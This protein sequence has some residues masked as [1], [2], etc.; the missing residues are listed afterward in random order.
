MQEKY[1]SATRTNLIAVEKGRSYPG[2][3]PQNNV[4]TRA[5]RAAVEDWIRNSIICRILGLPQNRVVTLLSDIG[6]KVSFRGRGLPARRTLRA[7]GRP[8]GRGAAAHRNMH[9]LGN[10]SSLLIAESAAAH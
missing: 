4:Y 3:T 1:Y 5:S 9:N 8:P 6:R 2:D 7:E 10:S